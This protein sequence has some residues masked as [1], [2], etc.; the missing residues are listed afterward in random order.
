MNYIQ[1][2]NTSCAD[3]LYNTSGNKKYNNRQNAKI[4]YNSYNQRQNYYE[5]SQFD[6]GFKTKLNK[7]SNSGY[8]TN[9]SEGDQENE[10]MGFKV[11]Q[12]GKI[13]F[14]VQSSDSDSSYSPYER[15][16]QPRE[17]CYA[18]ATKFLGPAAQK[19]SLPSFL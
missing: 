15:K 6:S 7:L 13:L 18:S 4:P 12:S 14:D 10:V 5:P 8:S 11:V 2:F 1:R 16:E 3:K 17:E 19:I 9:A